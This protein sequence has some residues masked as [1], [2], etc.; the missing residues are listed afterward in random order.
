MYLLQLA[1][2]GLIALLLLASSGFATTLPQRAGPVI[3]TVSGLDPATFPD[4]QVEFDVA[5]L[6]ALGTAEFDTSSIW[7]DGTHHYK[8]VML[9]A[10]S[11][12]LHLDNV[13]LRLHALNDYAIEFPAGEAMTTGPLL[14]YEV[15]GAPMPVRDKGPIWLLYPF[16]SGIDYRTDTNYSRS[17]WQLDRID[18]LR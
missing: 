15:D 8:G 12:F 11:D 2:P 10:L 13:G 4:G 17:I 7:T 16:D 9:K 1:R 18:V 14:A 6:E 3:L 5:M